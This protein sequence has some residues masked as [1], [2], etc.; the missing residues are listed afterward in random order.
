VSALSHIRIVEL[1]DGVAGEYCGK[2]LADFG[3]EVIKVERLERGSRTR[4][5]G[6]F[7]PTG[8]APEHSG[9]FAFLNTNKR[10]VTIDLDSPDG[11]AT[12]AKLLAHADAV[13]DD[14]PPGW[15]AGVGLDPEDYR[16]TWPRLTL[17]AITS[18]GQDAPP[19][20]T[21][22]EDLTVMHASGW[23]YHTPSSGEDDRPPLKGAGRFLPSYEAG[24]DGALCVVACLLGRDQCGTGRFIDVSTQAVMASR[25]DYVLNQMVAGDMDVG[26]ERS[27]FDLGGPA[28]IFPCRDGF[29]YIFM[30]T[31]AH[32][33]AFYSMIGNP[34]QLRDFPPNWLER[35][36]T[37]DRIAAARHH[38]VEWLRT[39]GKDQAAATAQ[40]LGLTL[41]PVNNASDLQRSPQFRHRGFFSEVDHPVI[42]R[43]A[44]PTVPYKL[45]QTPARI[46]RAAPLLGEAD[47]DQ[48]A[49]SGTARS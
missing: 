45:G 31:P 2:L 17:C 16:A 13:I 33:Q 29:I 46:V 6:P 41:V 34:E 39:Q 47:A 42:G 44:Y 30:T 26:T 10:S 49:A 14:H 9:L 43:A 19:D 37:P 21:H 12:L 3:A 27:R 40:E 18:F 25:V 15:L 36:L 11:V 7:A 4:H 22:A 28:G 8:A 38:L 35:G 24:L 48:L 1:A 20:R 32:W 23:G 5:L